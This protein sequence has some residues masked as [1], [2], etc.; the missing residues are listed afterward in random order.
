[1]SRPAPLTAAA[2]DSA[3]RLRDRA[4]PDGWLWVVVDRVVVA[5]LRRREPVPLSVSVSRP[6]FVAVG[7]PAPP[8]PARG[9]RCQA[10]LRNEAAELVAL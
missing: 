4:A 9:R 3:V 2:P 8:G 5:P 10:D 1:M 6:A 7:V